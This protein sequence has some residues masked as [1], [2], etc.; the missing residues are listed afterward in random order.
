MTPDS[1]LRPAAP[2]VTVMVVSDYRPGE[3]KSWNDLRATLAA[4]ANQDFDEPVEYLL[5]ENRNDLEQM[6]V[7]RAA[8]RYRGS[9]SSLPTP[10][11]PTS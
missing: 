1:A 9:A 11:V 3:E 5:L 10:A 4:L 8:R 2:A 7:G 6:P